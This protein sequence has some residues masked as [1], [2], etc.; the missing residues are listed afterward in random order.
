MEIQKRSY[1]LIVTLE[2]DTDQKVFFNVLRQR[3]FPNHANHL[4]AHL[5]MFHHLPSG[6]EFIMH[7][8]HDYAH[9][10]PFPLTVS[11]LVNFGKGVAF[12]LHSFELEQMHQELQQSFTQYLKRQD[13]KPIWP[14]ITIQNKVTAFKAQQTKELLEKDFKPFEINAIGFGIWYYIGGPWRPA[15]FIPFE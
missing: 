14:H 9:R 11:H 13:Q 3:Y 10:A 6:N 15:R 2:L 5:T 8:L 12:Q 7:T 1:P 4:E